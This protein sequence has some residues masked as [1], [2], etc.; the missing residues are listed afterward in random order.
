MESFGAIAQLGERYAG[1]VEVRGSIP[2]GSTKF[3]FKMNKSISLIGMAGAGKSTLGKKL[4]KYLKFNFV[5]SDLLIEAEQKKSLQEILAENGAQS[6]KDIEEKSLMSVKFN[7]TVLATG[8]SAIFSKSA[9]HYIGKQSTLIFIQ[10]TYEDIVHRISDF[11]QRGF[12][13]KPKQSIKEAFLERENIY[14][15]YA[16][17]IVQ[18]KSDIDH[19]FDRILE[20]VNQRL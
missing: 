10:V 16:D 7:K 19:C 5:D 20:I 4:A 2:L 15:D 13:K 17:F 6:F 3:K 8:G 14:K 18:N 9:M 12:I 11:S 1:S